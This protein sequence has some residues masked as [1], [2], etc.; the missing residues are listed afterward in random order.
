[1]GVNLGEIFKMGDID[2]AM[3]TS[4]SHAGFLVDRGG[5][6]CTHQNFNPNFV[7]LTRYVWIEEKAETEQV[8]TNDCPTLDLSHLREPLSNTINNILLC[9][10]AGT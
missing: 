2:I 5:H 6:K 10:Q 7:L 3:I 4:Y 9:L 8:S 1:M